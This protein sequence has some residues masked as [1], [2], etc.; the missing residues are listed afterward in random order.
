MPGLQSNRISLLI[1]EADLQAIHGAVLTLQ[2]KFLP[3][4][5]DLDADEHGHCRR[6]A[7]RR[8]TS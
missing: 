8:S 7:P 6:W 3:H 2:E 4:L 1:P 5:I